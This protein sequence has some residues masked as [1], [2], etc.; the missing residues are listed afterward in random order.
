MASESIQVGDQ[1]MLVFGCCADTRQHIGAVAVVEK[2]ENTRIHSDSEIDIYGICSSC[3]NKSHG[4]HAFISFAPDHYYIPVS[5]IKK[6]PPPA[7]IQKMR[8]ADAVTA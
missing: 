6:M 4:V 7:E 3:G 5:W 2:L 1:A 8:K